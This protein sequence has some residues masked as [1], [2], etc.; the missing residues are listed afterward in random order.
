MSKLKSANELFESFLEWFDKEK[1]YIFFVTFIIGFIVNILVITNDIVS[2]DAINLTEVYISS[3]WDL[4]LGRWLLKLVDITR[5]GIAS[6]VVCSTLSILFISFGSVLLNDLFKVKNKLTKYLISILVVVSPFVSSTLISVYCSP[7]FSLSFLLSIFAVYFI[8]NIKNKYLSVVLSTFALTFSLGLYQANL[9]VTCGLCVMIPLVRL[10]N[11]EM[12]S[13]EIFKY[14]FKS[15]LVGILSIISYEVIL[16]ILL[17]ATNTTMS[18]YGG[19]NN[20]GINTILNIHFNILNAFKTFFSY[21]LNDNIINNLI[22]RREYFNIVLLICT[23][24]II[25]IKVFNNEERKSPLYIIE[26][27]ILVLLIPICLS[28][29]TIVAPERGMYQLMSAPFILIYVLSLVLIEDFKGKKIFFNLLSY[30][31]IICI[32]FVINSYYVMTNATYMSN[33]ITKGRTE[34]MANNMVTDILKLPEYNIGMEVL[35]IG[36]PDNEFSSTNKVYELSS[37]VSLYEPLMW[38]EGNLCNRG[39]HNVIK[40]YLGVHLT[41]ASSNDYNFIVNSKEFKDMNVYPRE[42]Y[43]KIINGKIVVKVSNTYNASL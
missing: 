3:T 6:H 17:L 13:K 41:E 4:S 35:F 1:R 2:T 5:F 31:S 43:I 16:Q 38:A 11:S 30:V 24:I 29:L 8:Y 14:L 28:I 10:L 21:F 9:G 37:A 12:N 22:Y 32:L 7:D 26:I 33:R 40:Y 19:A 18:S 36:R 27:I 34:N 39:W 20:I 23:L 15:L 25:F 42:G